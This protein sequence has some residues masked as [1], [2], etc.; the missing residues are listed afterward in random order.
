ME[1]TSLPLEL[2]RMVADYLSPIDLACLALCSHLLLFYFDKEVFFQD[3]RHRQLVSSDEKHK[4]MQSEILI[5]LS[6]DWPLYLWKQITLQDI[7][8][9]VKGWSTYSDGPKRI[10]SR[11]HSLYYGKHRAYYGDYPFHFGHLLRVM[12]KFNNETGPGIS[13]ESLSYTEVGLHDPHLE[14]SFRE[15]EFVP[16][17]ANPKD[18]V[19]SLVSVEARICESP[20]GFYLRTQMLA[21]T[22]RTEINRLFPAIEVNF[23]GACHHYGPID[24]DAVRDTD[25][26]TQFLPRTL[27]DE[28]HPFGF[29]LRHLCVNNNEH[30]S[31]CSRC[32]TSWK[33]E[34][35]SVWNEAICVVLTRWVDLGRGLSRDD[36]KGRNTDCRYGDQGER[37]A[38][39]P[40]DD[41]R[42]RFER[43]SPQANDPD[44]LS[45][46]ALLN[47]N[48][49]LLKKQKYRE[50]MK[51]YPH[52]EPFRSGRST[53]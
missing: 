8:V 26:N 16:V 34:I 38:R 15:K 50:T 46:A 32:K 45:E 39:E 25:S 47:R 20:P 11:K 40:S 43:D 12:Q 23:L 4:R 29:F 37:V 13:P 3:P 53:R 35:H 24:Y 7:G 21:T 52:G 19:T 5:R 17:P 10:F 1:L 28:D 9:P 31:F 48:L 18:C 14:W 27:R 33:L 41:P 44:S 36:L 49:A 22:R 6:R 2:L 30:C 42:L 51:E